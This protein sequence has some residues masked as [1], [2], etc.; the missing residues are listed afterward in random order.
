MPTTHADPSIAA[1]LQDVARLLPS[2]APLHAFVHHNTL[3]AYE[4]LPFR[5][6][7]LQA[8]RELGGEPFMSEQA[9]RAALDSGRILPRDIEAVLE[10]Q[11]EQLDE[12]VFPGAPTR[13]AMLLWRLSTLFNVPRAESVKW[14]LHEKGYLDHAHRLSGSAA[15]A[16]NSPLLCSAR[17]HY[18]AT[19]LRSLWQ[20]LE[21]NTPLQEQRMTQLRPRDFCLQHSGCDTDEQVRPW[22]IRL[23]AAYLDQGVAGHSMPLREQG[24]L[25][26]F[27]ALYA[28]PA[29]PLPPWARGLPAECRRQQQLGLDAEALIREQLQTLDLP[30]ALWPLLLRETALALKGWAGMFVQFERHPERAPALPLPAT[31]ADFIAVQLTLDLQAAAGVARAQ[32][33]DLAQHAAQLRAQGAERSTHGK[34]IQD[35]Y[36]GFVTAQAFDLNVALFEQPAH[37]QAWIR[38]IGRFNSFERRYLLQ[39]AFERRHR[40]HVLDALHEHR[41]FTAAA[42]QPPTPALQIVCCMDER[43]ESLRRHLEELAPDLQSFGIAGFFG[44]AM[45]YRGFEDIVARPLC[46]VARK[47][48]HLVEEVALDAEQARRYQR[49]RKW[50]GLSSQL[51]QEQEQQLSLGPLWSL[52]AGIA[53]TPVL[54]LRSAF[55]RRFEQLRQWFAQLAPPRPA[56]RLALFRADD[57]QQTPE[58]LYR[59]YSLQEATAVVGSQLRALGLTRDFAALVLIAGHGSHSL[60]NPHEAAYD[61]GAAGGGRGGPNARALAAMA[62]HPQVRSAL[63]AEGIHIPQGC[64]FLGACHNT[65]DDSVEYYDTDL[66]PASLRDSFAR[67]QQLLRQACARNAVERCRKFEEVPTDVGARRAL[68][69][70]QRH[71]VDLAQPR[72]EYGHATNAICFIGRRRSTRGL[73]MDRRAFLISYEPQQDPTQDILAGILET[74]GPVGAGI[75]LEFYFSNVDPAVW[76]CGTKLPHNISGLIGVMEGHASDLRTGLSWQVVEIHEP[77]RLL[78]IVEAKPDALLRIAQERPAIGRLVCNE[79][80]QLVALDPDSGEMHRYT[81]AGFVR[82]EP[83]TRGYP[84]VPDS[85]Q[86]VRGSRSWL[87]LAHIQS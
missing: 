24:F 64:W 53:K 61:C 45:Q 39:L 62:N 21:S 23:A 58:G 75:N 83:E 65:C 73:F 15:S 5:E 27:R 60:N 67:L 56:T 9:F 84:V 13:R 52:C 10:E 29:T 76:G 43:E 57:S 20:A 1:L 85:L 33:L 48:Q 68:A 11:V 44:V 34:P 70:V 17:R 74:A 72:P 14:W 46:P 71:S 2:Q 69:A 81:P 78:T 42:P 47:P 87:G 80:I 63:A 6:G 50:Q 54:L 22:L 7:L 82:H 36:E 35:I 37:V 3:H 49:L 26:S 4:Q 41:R 59:G 55:P 79:W 30:R 25:A 77:L 51:A 28:L 19:Q 38:E 66:L 18:S 12:P 40:H 86:H 16:G 8:S 32:G 31:L